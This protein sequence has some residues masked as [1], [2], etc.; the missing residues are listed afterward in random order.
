MYA[1]ARAERARSA[2]QIDVRVAREALSSHTSCLSSASPGV[3]VVS[4]YRLPRLIAVF[5]QGVRAAASACDARAHT[6]DFTTPFHRNSIPIKN[7]YAVCPSMRPSPVACAWRSRAE[8]ANK[9]AARAGDVRLSPRC[10]H[11][12]DATRE[13]RGG[14]SDN[15]QCQ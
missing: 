13:M 1:V 6:I 9:Y 11:R 14:V 2:R 10:A 4:R 5:W 8:I 15:D 3:G 7:R 12:T